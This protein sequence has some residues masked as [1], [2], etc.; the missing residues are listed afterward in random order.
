MG[1]LK[2]QINARATRLSRPSSVS[3]S[4]PVE[5]MSMLK[6]LIEFGL[7]IDN[8]TPI[9]REENRPNYLDGNPIGIFAQK[10]DGCWH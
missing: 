4:R 8:V 3:D 10:F 2:F 9:E 5:I 7:T 1:T 6:K